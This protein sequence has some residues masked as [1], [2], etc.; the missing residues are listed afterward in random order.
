MA[1]KPYSYL[2]ALIGLIICISF[3]VILSSLNGEDIKLYFL[4]IITSA[5]YLG[6][7][8]IGKQ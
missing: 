6:L 4:I 7:W 2:G 8:Q 3:A 1:W 5:I